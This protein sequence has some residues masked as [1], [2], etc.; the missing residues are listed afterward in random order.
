MLRQEDGFALAFALLACVV[1]TIAATS[2]ITYTTSSQHSAN[3][4]AQKGLA[5][6][7]AESGLN[8]A[9]SVIVH[10]NSP[11]HNPAAANLLG[12]AGSSGPSDCSSPTYICT[13]FTSACPNTYTPTAGTAAVYGYFSGTNAQTYLGRSVPA[14]TWL[15]VSTGYARNEA[16]ALGGKSSFAEVTISPLS[17]GAVASVWNHIFLTATVP[18]GNPNSCQTTFGGNS[19]AI[20]APIYTIGNLCFTGNGDTLQETT[21]P[22]DLM[23]GGKLL[24]WGNGDTVGADS[25]HP[26]TS[27]VVVGG[28]SNSYNTWTTVACSS[29]TGN[30]WVKTTDTYISQDAPALT[31]AQATTDYGSFDPGPSHPCVSPNTGTYA[32]WATLANS[33]FDSNS[34]YDDS[35]ATFNLTPSSSYACISQNGANTG[36]IIW[37][38]TQKTLTINGNV[39][40]DGNVTI[41]QSLTYTGVGLI[42]ASGTITFTNQVSVCG[43]SSCS[44]SNWQGTSGNNQ[45]LSLDSLIS[46]NAAA[47][48]MPN[49]STTFQ[50]SFWTQ[51]TSGLTIGGN[52]ASIQGPLSIGSITINGNTP[53]FEP[54]PAIKN[55]PVGAPVPPNTS[56]SIGPLQTVG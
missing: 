24:F 14:S 28:C 13:S 12:C 55:M 37:D 27:G 44:F 46:N 42:M 54:L 49:Q 1:I 30:Y 29:L 56:A 8:A 31:T 52:S 2:V 21:Q 15:L 48:S 36:E 25:S 11:G 53:H 32:G 26:I 18:S 39:F 3:A 20:T 35:A 22:I 6:T 9:Y 7:Y 34:T 47:I 38:N 10:A 4:S 41:T 19:V 51:P 45:M 40:F 5:G 16:G 33:A 50:G 43:V 23:V 17:S